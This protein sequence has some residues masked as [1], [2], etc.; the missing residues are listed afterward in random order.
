VYLVAKR[1]YINTLPFLSFRLISMARPL[2][3][4]HIVGEYAYI[5][6]KNIITN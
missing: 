5:W 4:L 2:R 3:V 6:S 1:R